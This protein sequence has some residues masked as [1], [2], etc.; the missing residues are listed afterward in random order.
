MQGAEHAVT[1]DQQLAVMTLDVASQ[2]VH[3]VPPFQRRRWISI[4]S[5][6]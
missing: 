3:S 2:L 1:V 6:S 5:Y 4:D